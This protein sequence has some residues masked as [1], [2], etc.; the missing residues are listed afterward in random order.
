MELFFPRCPFPLLLLI[1]QS[2]G[3]V[4]NVGITRVH[5][6]LRVPSAPVACRD[7]GILRWEVA[8]QRSLDPAGGAELHVPTP[9]AP[10]GRT[11]SRSLDSMSQMRGLSNNRT[12]GADLT[13]L[14]TCAPSKSGRLIGVWFT[15]FGTGVFSAYPL[16]GMQH[17]G[18][19]REP[20]GSEAALQ[21]LGSVVLPEPGSPQTMNSLARVRA[22]SIFQI[23]WRSRH[24]PSGPACA[25]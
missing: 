14:P 21:C 19:G 17:P 16:A 7:V 12:P 11:L 23:M 5:V 6:A 4:G 20:D 8:V 18:L 1:R 3:I 9:R 24:F 13:K 15:A 10:A 22:L 2:V 25:A